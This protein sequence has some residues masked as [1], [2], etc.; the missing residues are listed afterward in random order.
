MLSFLSCAGERYGY[1]NGKLSFL[2]NRKITDSG[3]PMDPV[4][5]QSRV[6]GLLGI[7]DIDKKLELWPSKEDDKWAIAI[8]KHYSKNEMMKVF[9]IAD[10]RSVPRFIPRGFIKW[11]LKKD[12]PPATLLLDWKGKTHDAYKTQ[13]QKPN[14]FIISKLGKIAYRMDANYSNKAY[15]KLKAEIERALNTRGQKGKEARGQMGE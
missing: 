10:M 13:P 3:M 12:K 8:Q 4:D 9:I 15:N 14:I 1:H 7:Y 11:N 2:L 6:L 5:H